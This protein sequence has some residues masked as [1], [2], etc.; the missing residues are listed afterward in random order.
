MKQDECQGCLNSNNYKK[1]PPY[2]LL[3]GKVGEGGGG[4]KR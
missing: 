4:K 3:L 2:G 1:D